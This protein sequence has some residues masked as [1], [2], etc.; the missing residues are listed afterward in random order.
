MIE[1]SF[2]INKN[3]PERVSNLRTTYPIDIIP[4]SQKLQQAALAFDSTEAKIHSTGTDSSNEEPFVQDFIIE[5]MDLPPKKDIN[6]YASDIYEAMRDFTVPETGE[7]AFVTLEQQMALLQKTLEIIDKSS[8][9]YEPLMVV[10]VDTMYLQS[11]MVKWMQDIC[12]SGGA[13]SNQQDW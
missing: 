13:G 5:I 8:T 6:D 9:L 1:N 4:L 11:E 12:L 7:P 2:L 3:H 10:F